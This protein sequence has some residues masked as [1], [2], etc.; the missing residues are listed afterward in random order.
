MRRSLAVL[1]FV[2]TIA[3]GSDV[4][5]IDNWDFPR[6]LV[7]GMVSSE[8]ETIPATRV[9]VRISYAPCPDSAFFFVGAPT[10]DA[11][12]WYEQPVTTQSVEFRGCIEATATPPI[13]T[14][15]PP[16]QRVGDFDIV[17]AHRGTVVPFDLTYPD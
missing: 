2:G 6:F 12:G 16:L 11:N 9:D 5:I 15:L 13:S 14:G 8:G 17:V 4:V 3:C 7:V 10:T 1:L